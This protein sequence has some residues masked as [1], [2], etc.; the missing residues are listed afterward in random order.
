M[1]WFGKTIDDLGATD[2]VCSHEVD[3]GVV[4]TRRRL[5]WASGTTAGALLLAPGLAAQDDSSGDDG[6]LDLA[7]MLASMLA[8]A[9]DL[10]RTERHEQ[11]YLF[12]VADMIARLRDP[13]ASPR[14]SM[15]AFRDANEQEGK[16]FPIHV[17]EMRL[18]PGAHLR[19]HDHRDYNGVIVGVEGDVRIKNFDILGDDPTP[20]EGETFQIRETQDTFVTRGQFSMLAR[21]RN[22]VHDL[23]A[24][25]DGAKVLDVFT[26]FT[27]QATSY[28]MDVEAEPRDAEQ[29]IYDAKWRPRRRR[30]K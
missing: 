16:R 28:F 2:A 8:K 15:R 10:I 20:P 18:K 11:A 22:N 5:F 26:F 13:A 19:H 7:D 6:A 4:V 21:K 12:Q 9:N 23:V 25:K 3:D 1:S 27:R 30:K 17:T 14:K 24:G 29:R